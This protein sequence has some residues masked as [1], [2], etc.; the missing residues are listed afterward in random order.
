MTSARF[1]RLFDPGGA[2]VAWDGFSNGVRAM[3]V[4]GLS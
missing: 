3:S 1:V 4:T 2:I